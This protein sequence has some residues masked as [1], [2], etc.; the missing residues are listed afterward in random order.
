MV[1]YGLADDS[2]DAATE[3]A[4]RVDEIEAPEQLQPGDLPMHINVYDRND[5]V[6]VSA[7]ITM[8]ISAR[9]A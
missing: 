2:P 4:P 1:N 9:Q 7:V 6:V 8:W 3:T 5:V